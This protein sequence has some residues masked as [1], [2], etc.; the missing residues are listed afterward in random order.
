MIKTDKTLTPETAPV[1]SDC[2]ERAIN[3]TQGHNEKLTLLAFNPPYFEE[4]D[5]SLV[6]VETEVEDRYQRISHRN[7][8][9]NAHLFIHFF[10]E[11]ASA[12]RQM[13]GIN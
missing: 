13:Q 5:Y 10:E 3:D 8:V 7:F 4:D 11:A 12:E 6:V 1:R 9:I 2:V